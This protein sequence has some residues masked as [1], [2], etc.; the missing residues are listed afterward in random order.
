[1]NPTL[2]IAI[3]ASKLRVGIDRCAWQAN[4]ERALAFG[5]WIGCSA[6]GRDASPL[7]Y[8]DDADKE[9]GTWGRL[10]RR[11]YREHPRILDYFVLGYIEQIKTASLMGFQADRAVRNVGQ[12]E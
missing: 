12:K 9:S 5:C 7:Q 2:D 10:A 8:E 11:E 4:Q 1:M 6:D 3:T